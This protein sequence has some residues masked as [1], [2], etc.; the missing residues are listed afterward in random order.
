MPILF[1]T[2]IESGYYED[3]MNLQIFSQRLSTRYPNISF[4]NHLK[5]I[6]TGYEFIIFDCKI[7][8]YDILFF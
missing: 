1:D 3:A 4:L 5:S 2:L 6:I 7:I 8:V